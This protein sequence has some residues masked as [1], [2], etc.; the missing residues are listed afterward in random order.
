MSATPIPTPGPDDDGP[1]LDLSA[2][3]A[4]RR[5]N[6]LLG[7]KDNF[8]TDRT[9]ADDLVKAFPDARTAAVENRK[10]LQRVV[11]Y[12][13][14]DCGIRQFLDIGVGLP[15]TPNVHE[16]AQAA[17]PTSRVAYVDNDPV[18]AVHARALLTSTPQGKTQFVLGDLRQPDL[19]VHDAN[20]RR[21]L[22]LDQPIAVLIVAVLHF[23]T[24]TEHPYD[25]LRQI[26]EAMPT[27]SYLAIS[28]GTYDLIPTDLLPAVKAAAEDPTQGPLHARTRDQVTAFTDGLNLIEPGVVPVVDWHPD[29][30]PKPNATPA[31]S[32]CYGFLARKP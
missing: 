24:D 1:R 18:V 20:L 14:V 31:Q 16:I 27:G 4:A 13:A 30:E 8:E 22:N 19:I 17:D 11:Q 6:A 28:H 9:A 32:A 26:L 12:L 15:V 29:R 23:I 7:G 2:P 25:L 5:Y 3:Q 21:T 10:F